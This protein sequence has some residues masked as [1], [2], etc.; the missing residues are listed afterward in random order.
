MV[1]NI[2]LVL[3]G[4]I[5]TVSGGFIYDRKILGSLKE[6]GDSVEI[7]SLPW[8]NY[9]RGI[10]NSLSSTLANY[11]K[12]ASFDVLLQDELAHPSLFLLNKRIS[13][14]FRIPIIVIVHHLRSNESRA[15]W[16]NHMYRA[17]ERH[18]LASASGYICNSHETHRVVDSL[19]GNSKPSVVALPGGDRFGQSTSKD[20]IKRRALSPGPLKIIF[21]G[22]VIPRKGLNI[23]LDSIA[24]LPHN[25]WHLKV[26]GDLMFHSRYSSEVKR[27][28]NRLNI[29]G[30]VDFLGS[31]PDSELS[32]HLSMSHLL[33]V[34]SSYEGFG[35]VYLEAM[36]FGLPVIGST[37]GGAKE[38][39]THGVDGYLVPP[40]DPQTLSAHINSL[41]EN[42]IQL[43]AMSLAALDRFYRHPTWSDTG[44]LIYQFLHSFEVH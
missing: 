33:V 15:S 31:L 32:C 14:R 17:I 38:I 2:G 36:G 30:N 34:P 43:C 25:T 42:R 29:K 27:Q 37:S 9:Y 10:I 18:Y 6:A 5:D 19:T 23:L 12:V 21:L 44:R 16:K 41:I 22:N 26:V 24:L 3:N 8:V 4:H 13:Q 7:I 1:M 40:G 28:V 20:D 39:I 35:I 11:L